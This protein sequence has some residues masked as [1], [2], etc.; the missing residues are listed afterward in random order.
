MWELKVWAP[1]VKRPCVQLVMLL[2]THLLISW[3]FFSSPVFSQWTRTTPDP[4]PNGPGQRTLGSRFWSLRRSFI[5]T[6]IWPGGG[7]LRSPTRSVSPKGRSK[8]GFRT[9]G[10]NGRKTTN[11]PTRRA[12]PHQPPAICRV[13]TRTRLISRHY[14]SGTRPTVTNELY[15]KRPTLHLPFAWTDVVFLASLFLFKKWPQQ[16]WL[17]SSGLWFG[18]LDVWLLSGWNSQEK[19]RLKDTEAIFLIFDFFYFRFLKKTYFPHWG[20]SVI[21]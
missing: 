4:S 14:K 2:G 16:C 20:L 6:G 11:Y 17:T 8:F 18:M 5:L 7:G 19:K 1:R 3:L 13:S 12:D 9:D 21:S 15:I 10:W